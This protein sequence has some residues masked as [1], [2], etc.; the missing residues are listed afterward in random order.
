M[1]GDPRV[2]QRCAQRRERLVVAHRKRDHDRLDGNAR[3]KRTSHGVDGG[4]RLRARV[5]RM[6][7][8]DGRDARGFE[9]RAERQIPE[10]RIDRR[11]LRRFVER[12]RQIVRDDLEGRAFALGVERTID[13]REL[14]ESAPPARAPQGYVERSP[15]RD[16]RRVPRED[17]ARD[18]TLRAERSA[19]PF[20]I[21]IGD[22]AREQRPGAAPVD[23][24]GAREERVER[25]HRALEHL[26]A[27]RDA[28][29]RTH[30]ER[31]L[32]HGCCTQRRECSV[33]CVDRPQPRG[34]RAARDRREERVV[35]CDLRHHLGE[36]GAH[37][38]RRREDDLRR[39]PRQEPRTQRAPR[40]DPLAA[41][42]RTTRE[43]LDVTFARD[44][45]AQSRSRHPP[46][47]RT[48]VGIASTS[49]STGRA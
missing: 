36:R 7:Y 3:R 1:K 49:S 46:D 40:L 43:P 24:I 41:R 9:R 10:G 29:W 18:R 25:T 22:R 28:R 33:D 32:V 19:H 48:W 21:A 14:D 12:A 38:G 35:R 16:V 15:P 4:T 5:A 13:R 2:V 37:F 26:H 34:T 42:M 45:D 44:D 11:E 39:E 20:G 6:T 30:G 8:L 47:L 31:R 27:S 23:A 17:P